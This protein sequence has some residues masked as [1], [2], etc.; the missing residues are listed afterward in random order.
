MNIIEELITRFKHA[1]YN[2]SDR[3]SKPNILRFLL[4][5][6][7][8]NELKDSSLLTIA[9]TGTVSLKYMQAFYQTPA[10]DWEDVER[11]EFLL[12]K[13]VDFDILYYESCD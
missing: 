3:L 11:C 10:S 7:L 1:V 13:K 5:S 6:N 2:T 4:G 12:K 8:Q 9:K